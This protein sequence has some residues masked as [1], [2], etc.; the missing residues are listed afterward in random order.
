[1]KKKLNKLAIGF[2][3]MILGLTF[4][5]FANDIYI[6]QSGD[7]LDL[8]ITQDGQNNVAGTS[9][10]DIVLQGATM[11]FNIDQV[12][13]SNIVSA[14]IKGATYTGNIDLTGDS[15]DVELLCSSSASGNCDTVSMSVDVTGDSADITVKIGETA[16]AD[17][18]TGTLDIT[19]GASETITLTVDGKSAIADIDISNAQGSAGNTATYDVDG[20]GD[21]NGH[22]L[23]H[24]HTGDGAV[25]NITQSGIYDSI[26]DLTTSGDNQNIDITQSD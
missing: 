22:S 14:T 24:S 4:P 16:D 20:D 17:T 26:V 12:G 18:F 3:L 9:Q 6:Q 19:S 8:D 1:M 15:N 10:A 7:N 23:T 5:V 13:N 21:V 25:I 2:V 11:T